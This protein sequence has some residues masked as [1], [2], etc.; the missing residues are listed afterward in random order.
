MVR[1]VYDKVWVL[2]MLMSICTWENNPWEHLDSSTSLTRYMVWAY[3][4][5]WRSVIS[6]A[7][8]PRS[9]GAIC[10]HVMER[11]STI[12]SWSWLWELLS[13]HL[14]LF[15]CSRHAWDVHRHGFPMTFQI[16]PDMTS[17]HR[18][19]LK[20]NGMHCYA[21]V[22]GNASS[23]SQSIWHLYEQDV[24]RTTFKMCVW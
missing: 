12:Q 16:Q 21:S 4:S 17:L 10:M 15:T 9:K 2:V 3:D 22:S 19:A 14:S 11:W 6:L 18:F 13:F 7:C 5:W 20:L 1:E 8:R 23:S 24:A